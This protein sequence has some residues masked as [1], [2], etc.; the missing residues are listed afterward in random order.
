V[1]QNPQ[2]TL[3]K[4]VPGCLGDSCECPTS[5]W[6]G[7]FSLILI[8]LILI[9][10]M[11][12]QSVFNCPGFASSGACGVSFPGAFGE[13]FAVN[14]AYITNS[15]PP[16]LSGTRVILSQAGVQHTAINMNYQTAVNVQAFTSTF[17]FIPN[18]QYITFTLNNSTNMQ[19]G[20]GPGLTSGAGGE[21]SIFQGY[22]ADAPY[23][24]P[25][26]IF[27]LSLDSYSP[28]TQNGQFTYSSAQI[29][30]QYQAP[31]LPADQG[32]IE[33]WP[34]NKISTYPVPLDSPANSQN[35]T[36]GDTYSAT[37]T[38]TGTYFRLDLYDV[39][40]G[41]SCPGSSCFTYLWPV[42]IP[43]LVNGTTAYVGLAEGTGS[44]ANPYN[45]YVNSWTYTVLN[46]A[47]N[48]AFSV[49]GGTYGGTQAVSLSS[50]SGGAVICYNTT[51]APAT[52]GKTGCEPGSTRY[53]GSISVSSSE[54]LYAVAGGAGY[55][56]SAVVQASYAIGSTAAVPTFSPGGSTY[57]QGAQTVFLSS[58]T[59]GA[60]I[61]Y[62][63]NGSTPTTSSTAYT[64][65]I[66]VSSNETIKAIATASGM[67]A[68]DIGSVTYS[69]NP[70]A[71]GSPAGTP[72]N[73]PKF[74]P[75]PGTYAGA[76]TVSLSSTTAGA[77]ICYVVSSTKPTLM[78][79]PD[80]LGGC[81]VGTNYS[82][83][84][85]V[86]SSETV[87]AAAGLNTALNCCT[88]YGPPSSVSSGAYVIGGK[89][90]TATP[91]ISPGGGTFSAAQT[92]SISDA[93]AG[94]TIYYTTN[95]S[96]PTTSSSVYSG[97]ITVS[98][99]ETIE[100]MAVA[101]GDTNSGVASATFTINASVQVATPVLSPGAGTYTSAQ[102]VTIS[103]ATPGATIYYTT[104][105]SAPTTSST[106][107]SGPITVSASETIEAIAAASG[108]TNSGVASA[109]YIINLPV[110]ATPTF[111]PAGGTYTS[112]QTVSIADATPGATIYYTTNGSTPTTSS[113]QYTGPIT[114]S[115]TETLKA[116]A[117]ATGDTNSGIATATYTI[118]PVVATPAISPAGGTYTSAQTVSISDSTSG[119]TIYY[120]TNG[121]T[122]TASST[123][124]T[125][126]ITVSSTETVE[127]IAAASGDSNSGVASATFTITPVVATPAFSPA[128]GS[129][130][131]AQTVSISDTTSGATIYYTTNGSTPTT[132]S[133][134]YTGPVT[135][136]ST[137]TLEAIAAASGDTNSAVASATYTINLPVVATPVFTPASGTYTSAQSVAI[138]D[139]TSGASIFYTT[140]GSTPTTSSTLYTGPITVSATE[141]L[142][143]LAAAS[144]DTNSAVASAAYTIAQTT[145]TPTFSPAAGTYTTAQTVSI[146]DATSG[147]T[148]YYTTNGSTPTTSSTPY[149]G[150]ITVS[151]TETLEAIAVVTGNSNSAVASAAYTISQATATP[152]F[153]PAAG[154]YTTAQTVSIADTTSGATIY[155]TTNGST[156][157]TSSTPY[158]GPITVSATETLEAIA[159]STGNSNSAVASAAYT[160]SATTVATPTFSPAAGTYTA[161]QTVSIADTTSGAT[162]YYTTNG[163]APTTSSTPYSG[164]ITVSATETLEAIAVATGDTNSGI[165]SATY[166][167]GSAPQT[168]NIAIGTTVQQAGVKRLGINLGAQDFYD[169]GQLSRNL[170]VR[171]PG[172]EAEIWSSILNCQAATATTCTDSDQYA[173]WPANFLQGATFQFLYGGAKGQSGTVTAS[174]AANGSTGV[175]LTFA[176]PLSPA[177]AAGDV[178]QVQMQVPG[179]PQAGWWVTPSGGATFSADTSDLSPET[180][181]KQALS[182]NAA[183]SGQ[184]AQVSSYFDSTAGRSFVQLNGTYTLTFRAK[185]VSGSNQMNVSFGRTTAAH[186][187]VSY[188]NQNVTLTNQ[189]QDYSYS[190]NAAED[191]TY[192]GTAAL[193]FNVS[194]AQV[195]LDDVALTEPAAA[196]NPTVFRNAVLST[197][198][199]LQPGVLRY[200]DG[201][202]DFAS[203]TA[204]MLA[205]PFARQRAGYGEGQTEQDDIS[206][207]L[208][209]FLVLTQ[210]VG[211]EPWYTV[212]AGI[213][214][215]DMQN[216]IQ[217][218]AGDASTTYGAIRASLGQSAP[219]TS[220]F[221][222]IHLE[223]GNEMW[224]SGSFAG[225]AVPNAAAY[226]S[227]VSTAFAAARASAS[228]NPANFDLVMGSWATQPS[229]TTQ[230]MASS[231]G[232]DSVD[233]APYLFNSLNDYGSNEAIFGPMFAQPEQVDSSPTASGNYMYQ[234]AQ[235]VGAA[236][237][238]AKLAVYEVNLSTTSGTAGQ[239]VVTQAAAGLGAGIAVADH[240][241]LMMR[242]LGI[243]TQNMFALPEYANAF[244]NTQGGSE[245]TPLWGSVIDMGGETNLQRPQFLAEQLANSAILPT[246]LSTTVSGANPTWNQPLSTNDQIQLANA[247]D[248]QSFAFTD[249]SHYNVVVLNLSRNSSL[250]VTFS[251]SNAPTGNVV[252][253]QLTSANPTDNNEGLSA[254]NPVVPGPTQT[255]VSNFN[256]ATPYSLPPYSMTVF[257][258]PGGALP[259]SYTTLQASP[260]TATAGQTVTLTAT[261][262]A[263]SGTTTPTGTIT[264]K[265]G[266][267]TLGTG[268]LNASGMATLATTML[269]VGTDTITAFYGGDTSD[270]SSVSEPVNVTITSGTV[271]TSTALVASAS[272][273]TAGQSV[274]FTAT[275]TPASGSNV[276]TGTVT[277][278][279]G[280]TSLGSAQLNGSGVA[281][282]STTSL[283][284]GAQSITA[285]YGGDTR[286]LASTSAAVTVTVGQG[287]VA[288]TTTLAASPTQLS[289][290]QNVTF[291]ATVVPQSG[292]NVPTGTVTFKDGSTVLGT[293]RLN[294]SGVA[295][296]STTGLAAGT[297]LITASYGGDGKDYG[298]ISSAVSVVVTAGSI[299]TS[300]T[301]SASATQIAS[302]QSVTF[303][304][305]VTPQTGNTTATGTVTFLDGTTALGTG[306]LNGSGVA[307]FSTTTLPSGT[308]SITASYGGSSSDAGS[309]SA[310]VS[311]TVAGGTVASSTT[312]TASATQITLG[313]SVSF[314]ATVA[315]QSGANVPTGTITFKD[316]SASLGT[317]RLN[318]SGA[319]TFATTALTTGTHLI[320]ASYGGDGKDYGSI[321]PTVTV[322]VVQSQVTGATT[323]TLSASPTQ[324]T[325]GQTV[326]FTATV[327]SQSGSTV[328]TG[329]VTFLDG[330]TTL[331]TATLNASGTASFSTTSLAAGIHS[332]VASYAGDNQNGASLS[333]AVTVTI[334]A[335][336]PGVAATTTTLTASSQQ[337]LP[338]DSVTLT[339]V[340]TP[341]SGSNVP[342]GTVTFHD[343]SAAIGTAQLNGSGGATLTLPS[344][345][346]GT[347]SITASYGGDFN[348]SPSIS[349]ALSI[350]VAEPEYAMVVNATSVNL[351]M[352]QPSTVGVTLIPE[353]GFN[354]PI[355]LVCSGLPKGTTCSFTPST[356]TPNGA[357]VNSTLTILTPT[358][359]AS[360]HGARP[361]GCPGNGLAFGWV[362][363][364]G[365]IPLLGFATKA[366]RRSRF[367]R[368]PFRLVV[369]AILALGTLWVSGCGYSS[370]GGMYVVTLTASA[371]NAQTH[372]SQITV[373]V[374]Q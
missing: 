172:F 171:N 163:S 296:F 27:A 44:T 254:G 76:Q 35:T 329:T 276:P 80:T 143:A 177:P 277:F 169:S 103:D 228:Y 134:P 347:H 34:T 355:S 311:V 133:T 87:Y 168:T 295:T 88:N 194:G 287:T 229:W 196:N 130:T 54:T 205:V 255:N 236:S 321:S 200:M 325:Q 173:V 327:A 302:G 202:A 12:G 342:T 138:S 147:A 106:V 308:Q 221:P 132:A 118:T 33:E 335:G 184:S 61:Y 99:S 151:A 79:Q 48:P 195:Y 317:A 148:I 59:P 286:D 359:S 320:T 30:Q 161:A 4:K 8:W 92:V 28:L 244:T 192:V 354:L 232:Y 170:T 238:T 179:N 227:M 64:G 62:T 178:I 369:A 272:T 10:S 31:Y 21:Q 361:L 104:N 239:S 32:Y 14:G 305:T 73:S 211:A 193:T 207:G 82:S 46:A 266:S 101:S 124:Y 252:I 164:P 3:Y 208:H 78:P 67:A 116:M 231:S 370:N 322:V 108:D 336:Q 299:A 5:R 86:S 60:V 357:P 259:A 141:T 129:Y 349:S 75:L 91:A 156:P 258:W 199:T 131:S 47:S 188:L 95:G 186:G 235:A 198:R 25:N 372:T 289:T 74:S 42:S 90:V 290:G 215:A 283:P 16:A 38:Y 270:A 140:N 119:A 84:I 367:A 271:A 113:S 344:L 155:Y 279:D 212:P 115:A 122:P 13:P 331:G 314:T 166:T 154:T 261:V 237:S 57:Y 251:G 324:T 139:T 128:G 268:T 1:N 6:F 37:V 275:V 149:T 353:N 209:D 109:A 165:A 180:P 93:T 248:L 144:G 175:T 264:F 15:D 114:V 363:P 332:I 219:W 50:S 278:L 297:Q 281:T 303:T 72:P 222:T 112:A 348:D 267:T 150:P 9:P 197:L 100:A 98:S 157:T 182:I 256:P 102:T 352:G 333:V 22:A 70:F 218:L 190:F 350:D 40:A 233:F 77:N 158:S 97:P 52:D 282:F 146:A 216:L 362:M 328:P 298:S 249:G 17:T 189:W 247:H 135:V 294:G 11:R 120:T 351:T 85:T 111:S 313:Q 41:G 213:S 280:S 206:I 285:A 315:P 167:I 243:T 110:V 226:G 204:N 176:S 371:S 126:P 24:S 7:V 220:V 368:W 269:P 310:P 284:T 343:G 345:A 123:P 152:T 214:A 234:Q 96:T 183:A 53:T 159:V 55:G 365:F 153:S 56:D 293:S 262:S 339:A 318:G 29:Y 65:P 334:T 250:P 36:T 81:M 137:E 136:S 66:T 142:K 145:A 230:E 356:V 117:A 309:V 358:T 260:T 291:T 185:A 39:S 58:S 181:G 360:V 240:M 20:R 273:I 203:T 43:T 105:G 366:G 89:P 26:N 63:T 316:G 127:A 94:A 307:T 217:Y 210:A 68:S 49:A 223:L 246:M 245:T 187:N 241:L 312:L 160:I 330:S 263:Q 18:A 340:V 45:L 71:S 174:T 306:T 346:V 337:L 23:T 326:A 274:T 373:H 162:I 107:Y 364:W 121:S 301:L 253:G 341:Q 323:T 338:A 300:T 288:S 225:E 224:N 265:N 292:S 2:P 319:A 242:D 304:A 374:Q 83:P 125:G 19:N 201:G 51:G 191:G 257:S 69:I